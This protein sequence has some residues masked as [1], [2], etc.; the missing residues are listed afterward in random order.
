MVFAGA[1]SIATCNSN[2]D[3]ATAKLID[4]LSG[5]VF[6][7]GDDAFQHGAASDFSSCYQPT[8]GRFVSRTLPALG[9]HDYDQGNANG[10][11][12]YYGGKL[13]SQGYYSSDINGWHIVVLN[14]N[15]AFGAG[16][17]QEQW[18]RAD[19]AA[20]PSQCTMAIWHQPMFFSSTAAGWNSRSA[21]KPIWDDLAAAG[22]DLVVNG[23]QYDYE[24]LAP[25]R[26]DGTRD[27]ALGIREFNVGTGGYAVEMP[28]ARHP[29]SEVVG[30]TLGVLKLT[31][32]ADHYD[33]QF[34][35]VAG[36]S[37]TDS[38]SNACH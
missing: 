16:S 37:F 25:M 1:G 23:H 15:I 19:L 9:N 30:A 14:D 20:H 31:L 27:D 26:P 33:W 36:Q 18:L 35:S 7:A 12:G 11:F 17:A 34:L 32:Y 21:Y 29:N 28:T 10:A 38:G 2:N 3:E 4:S 8:W 22:A 6:T 5:Y 13:G 24:R